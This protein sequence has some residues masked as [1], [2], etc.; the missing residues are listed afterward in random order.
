MA[1]LANGRKARKERAV[2]REEMDDGI[3][4]EEDVDR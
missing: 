2:R 1:S 4:K 3:E